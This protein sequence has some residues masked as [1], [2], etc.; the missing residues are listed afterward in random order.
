MA[1]L[2]SSHVAELLFTEMPR[3]DFARTIAEMDALLTRICGDQCRLGWD[4]DDVA[5]FDMPGTRILLSYS[6]AAHLGFVARL[7]LSVGPSEIAARPG[8]SVMVHAALCRRIASR[9]QDRCAPNELRWRTIP[10]VVVADD[11]DQLAEVPVS[12]PPRVNIFQHCPQGL[13]PASLHSA[14]LQPLR[15]AL[16]PRHFATDLPA[17]SARLAATV[18]QLPIAAAQYAAALYRSAQSQT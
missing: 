12:P 13:Q 15:N 16:R 8:Q 3:C 7:V 6:D 1:E 10:G 17:A 18:A 14:E 4:H 5:S 11:I 2:H 9:L